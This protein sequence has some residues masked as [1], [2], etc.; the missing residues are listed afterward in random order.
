[1]PPIKIINS[2]PAL[3]QNQIIRL[4]NDCLPGTPPQRLEWL[5]KG[6]PAGP[7]LWFLAL[8]MTRGGNRLIGTSTIMPKNF[9]INN[10]KVGA[11][12]LGDVMVAKEYRGRNLGIRIQKKI[13]NEMFNL[14]FNFLYVVPNK[15]SENIFRKLGFKELSSLRTLVRPVRLDHFMTKFTIM[16][17]WENFFRFIEKVM[18]SLCRNIHFSRS[19][20][21]LES[22]P[23]FDVSF[24]TKSLKC[25]RNQGHII[26]EKSEKYLSWRFKKNPAFKFKII[27]CKEPDQGNLLAYCIYT[28]SNNKLWIY[29]I[30]LSQ[31][32]NI[33]LL[34]NKS[35]MIAQQKGCVGV[36]ICLSQANP[37]IRKIKRY[38]FIDTG[39][40]SSILWTGNLDVDSLKWHFFSGDRNI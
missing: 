32:R 36:Y 38:C 37:M 22:T 24:E 6:N 14:G 33:G 5:N 1:M 26:A 19:N 15:N 10:K 2:G 11:G 4:W 20:I 23:D 31:D 17:L 21:M 25:N 29:D 13:L 35:L 34:L 7:T 27:L 18:N 8:D 28:I 39:D 40:K 9:T 30:V 3:Y 12:I 16:P